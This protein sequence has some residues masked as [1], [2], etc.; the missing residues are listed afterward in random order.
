MDGHKN[1]DFTQDE[2]TILWSSFL[3]DSRYSSEG[4]GIYEGA[5]TYMSRC[6]SS[7]GRQYD[8][9]QIHV[10]LM[11]RHEKPSTTW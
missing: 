6:V 1:V 9:H 4:I 10:D 3:K 5:C 2:N 11:H 7:Y 8:E